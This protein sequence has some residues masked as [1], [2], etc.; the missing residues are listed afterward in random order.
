MTF[1]IWYGENVILLDTIPHIVKSNKMSLLNEII[2][3]MDYLKKQC[4][5]S[6][7]IPDEVNMGVQRLRNLEEEVDAVI[8]SKLQ[9]IIEQLQLAFM[10][11]KHCRYSPDVLSNCVLWDKYF[12]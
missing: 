5:F 10:H 2:E 12:F 1:K 4:N 6:L 3:M 9:I 11:I 8:R 7:S